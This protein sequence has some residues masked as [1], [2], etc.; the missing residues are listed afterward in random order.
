MTLRVKNRVT[1]VDTV[2]WQPVDSEPV[3]IP[4]RF[5]R[6]VS[7]EEQV[8]QGKFKVTPQWVEIKT[9][10]LKT[11]GMLTLRNEEGYFPQVQPTGQE[12]QRAES[13]IL[14]V[15][16]LVDIDNSREE[17]VIP[18]ARILPRESLRLHPSSVQHLRVRCPGGV[19]RVHVCLIPGD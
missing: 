6:E 5:Y 8:Y 13:L 2:Y 3:A 14:E 19:A 18:F 9:W 16:L 11:V 7:C 1:V 10:W 15:G 4:S 12:R 17:K